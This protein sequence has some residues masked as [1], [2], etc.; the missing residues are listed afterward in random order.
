MYKIILLPIVCC[1][2]ILMLTSCASTRFNT[3]SDLIKGTTTFIIAKHEVSVGDWIAYI[4]ATSFTEDDKIIKLGD[5]WNNI[6]SKLPVF[7]PGGW[8]HYTM[9]AFLRNSPK[10]VNVD[11]YNDCKE[12]ITKIAVAESAWDSI[13]EYHLMDLPIA[14]ITY[15]QAMMYIQYKQELT[16]SCG[17]NAKDKYRYECFLPTPE[18]FESIQTALDSTNSLGCN[19]FNYKNS[20][21]PDCPNG[22]KFINNPIASRT[23][24]EP[25][26]VWGYFPDKFGLYNFKGNVAEM[27][28]V[29]GIAAGGSCM[30]YASE[31]YAGRR[32]VYLGS[33]DWLGFRVWYSRIP[34]S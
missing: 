32:L 5:H 24:L 11:F 9:N 30:H 18:E 19:L 34:Q 1:F 6:Y 10:N 20:L 7:K 14:G 26:S 4:A 31:A 21:C 12:R 23:G 27:T 33:A 13:R 25:T 28:S 29:K 3:K 22:E 2:S 16:N 17:F 15:E 8:S